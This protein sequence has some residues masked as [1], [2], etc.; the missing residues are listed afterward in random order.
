MKS[1]NIVLA[2]DHDLIRAGIARLLESF[3]NISIVGHARDGQEAIAI[4]KKKQPDIIILDI[5]MPKVNGVDA[6]GDIRH[7]AP[8][9]KIIILSMHNKEYYIHD[10]MK[11]GASAYLLK[12]S[13]VHEFK[14]AIDYV[15]KGEVYL[16]PA[17]S[18]TVVQEWLSTDT[19]RNEEKNRLTIRERQ[20]MKLLA[21]GFSN[22]QIAEILFISHKTV[23]TH[24]SRIY[25]KLDIDNIADL[26]RYAIKEGFTS[27][28]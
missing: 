14:D 18:K 4:V 13:A 7:Y 17:I 20:V 3:G 12:D 11:Q 2:D 5:S 6:I 28:D 10:C 1:I 21:E 25:G 15:M 9:T 27:V 26:V 8:Q 24:R 22:K 23:E 19:H 16:S